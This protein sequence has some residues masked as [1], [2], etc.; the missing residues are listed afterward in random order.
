VDGASPGIDLRVT[1][2]IDLAG[3]GTPSG[4]ASATFGGGRAGDIYVKAGRITVTGGAQINGTTVGMGQGG[5]LTVIADEA[6][7]LSGVGVSSE[8]VFLSGLATNALDKGRQPFCLCSDCDCG[9]WDHPGTN[10]C[11]WQCR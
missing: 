11:G 7:V 8:G 3:Q 5:N 1:E 2:S 6:L 10:H 4:L 9:R